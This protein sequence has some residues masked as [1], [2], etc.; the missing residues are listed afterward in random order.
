MHHQH[1]PLDP[2]SLQGKILVIVPLAMHLL[3][4]EIRQIDPGMRPAHF[5]LLGL[6]TTREWTLGELADLQ[7][8]SA[9]TMSGT[10]R[11]FEDRGWV[12]RERSTEDRRVV[13]ITAT[14]KGREIVQ[15][16]YRHVDERLAAMIDTL[17]VDEQQTLTDGLDIL[18]RMF[19]Q[20]QLAQCEKHP[21]HTG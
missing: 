3:A 15:E 9:P 6:L 17:S 5:R 7:S 8:V 11:M 1:Y 13:N 4:S 20:G 12:S 21:D 16:A 14:Q 19:D 10:V 18:R 2:A